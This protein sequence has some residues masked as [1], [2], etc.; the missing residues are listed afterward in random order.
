MLEAVKHTLDLELLSKPFAREDLWV[1]LEWRANH[2]TERTAGELFPETKAVL[3]PPQVKGDLP[4]IE[5]MIVS[6]VTKKQRVNELVNQIRQ[7]LRLDDPL[8][9][10][11]NSPLWRG[12]AP[13]KVPAS[14]P[15]EDCAA[16]FLDYPRNLAS[17]INASLT[18]KRCQSA[19][20]RGR[21]DRSSTFFL[22]IERKRR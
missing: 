21:R 13:T 5:A 3:G 7:P 22:L 11:Q 2:G 6:Q 10:A 14:R 18:L 17:Q 1:R 8:D 15:E 16:L 4:I 20:S 12:C 9:I 19:G